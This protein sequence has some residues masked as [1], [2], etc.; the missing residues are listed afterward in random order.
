MNFDTDI[1]Q[2]PS[3][4][5]NSRGNIK[6][7]MIVIHWMAG[8]YQSA[9]NWFMHPEAQ[10]SPHLAMKGDGSEISQIVDF[11]KRAWHAGRAAW[12]PLANGVDINSCSIGIELEGP[13]GVVK[14]QGWN[15]ALI[16]L[17]WQTCKWIKT[18]V[19]TIIGITDHSTI[20][21]Q[22]PWCKT[23]VLGGTGINTFPWEGVE[24]TGLE[25]LSIAYI[26]QQVRDHFKLA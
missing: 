11:D 7:I 5:F 3:P 26:R 2:R 17:L 18:K 4:N 20:L 1:K 14:T 25:D 16:D 10:V 24:S 12:H 19:P 22:P 13:P 6:P 21:P 8:S 9:L 15:Q 23:D